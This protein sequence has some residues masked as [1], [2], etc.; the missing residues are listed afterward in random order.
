MKHHIEMRA[1]G[2]MRYVAASEIIAKVL[3]AI[4]KIGLAD[5]KKG[6]TTGIR[7]QAMLL[8]GPKNLFLM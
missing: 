3:T 1:E 7:Y 8:S 6:N 5:K 2:V 4:L